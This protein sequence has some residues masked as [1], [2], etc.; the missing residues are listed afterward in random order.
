MTHTR[1]NGTPRPAAPS[2][3]VSPPESVSDRAAPVHTTSGGQRV[4]LRR[5]RAAGRALRTLATD[6]RTGTVLRAAVR[7]SM[8]VAAW[9]PHHHPPHLGRAHRLPVRADD[10]RR[11]SRG[12][13]RAGTGVGRARAPLPRRASQ[14]AHGTA[15]RRARHRQVRNRRRP[16]HPGWPGAARR[17]PRC[18]QRGHPRRARPDHGGDRTR[19]LAR[20]DRQR[21]M[22]AAA[23]GP[24]VDGP[25]R[26]VGCRPQAAGRPELGPARPS[27][28]RRRAHHPVHRRYR[29]ARP[30]R[31]RPAQGHHRDGRRRLPPC[32]PRSR[33]PG[34]AS[35]ST[36]PCPPARPPKR[37]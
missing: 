19:P 2:L 37:S 29:P 13:H 16:G 33:S 3:P 21:R 26:P 8:Y 34:A 24:A 6:E 15:D 25:G 20:P 23:H 4:R 9:N 27:A 32:S 18:R 36:S 22:G 17:R 28:E 14:A 5:T 35:R 10:A 30:G 1:V 12:E 11:R 7:H 31:A